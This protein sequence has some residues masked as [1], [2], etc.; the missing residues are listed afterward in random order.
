MMRPLGLLGPL[1]QSWFDD[2]HVI[3]CPHPQI[4]SD[5]LPLLVQF[6]LNP[7]LPSHA[8]GSSGITS[9]SSRLVT[10][11]SSVSHGRR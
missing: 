11:T 7:S 3:G 6:E 10:A 9:S 1:D 2:N 8:A 4:P 5:H